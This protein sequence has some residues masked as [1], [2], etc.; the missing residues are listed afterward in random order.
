MRLRVLHALRLA[1]LAD[2]AAVAAR[3]GL[4]EAVAL[5]VLEAAASR[6]EVRRRE[7]RLAGWILTSAG[8]AAAEAM[9]AAEL[10]RTGA[11]PRVERAYG[12]FLELNPELLAA[13]TAWQVRDPA[14]G[15]LNDHTDARY[16]SA[17]VDRLAA[18]HDWVRPICVDLA[19][20]LDRFAG[21]ESRMARALARVRAGETEWFARPL[22]DSYHTVWFELH[23]DLLA[24][25]GVARESESETGSGPIRS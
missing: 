2:T 23:E 21:Y 12:R 15:A 24:T 8:R 20:A 25:L 13:C 16:D 14:R 3:A 10:D 9:L 18:V 6:D 1:G 22:V 7:G 4:A 5:Q 11:R 17:V 19:A